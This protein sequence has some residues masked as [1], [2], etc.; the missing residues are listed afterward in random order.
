MP[1]KAQ[2]QRSLSMWN[3]T[4][5]C[6]GTAVVLSKSQPVFCKNIWSVD[7]HMYYLLFYIFP[8]SLVLSLYQLRNITF[9]KH[10]CTLVQLGD[11]QY[12]INRKKV[13]VH[14][15]RRTRQYFFIDFHSILADGI[16]WLEHT[17]FSIHAKYYISD[18]TMH[19]ISKFCP[20]IRDTY[21]S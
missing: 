21:A 17:L 16:W 6:F 20:Y 9:I 13:N 3:Y 1:S 19:I 2:W 7:I 14:F 5:Y 11:M 4:L 8:C 15:S 12:F 10:P 18:T